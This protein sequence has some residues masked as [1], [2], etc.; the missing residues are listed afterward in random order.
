MESD[1][2]TGADGTHSHQNTES[3]LISAQNHI[4]KSREENLVTDTSGDSSGTRGTRKRKGNLDQ[5]P[6]NEQNVVGSMQSTQ[7]H[8]SNA[9][10]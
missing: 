9:V 2:A 7:L 3:A 8:S 4:A 5:A 10:S 1:S 6:G